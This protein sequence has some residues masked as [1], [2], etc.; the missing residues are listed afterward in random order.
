[1]T[2]RAKNNKAKAAPRNMTVAGATGRDMAKNIKA[3]L[4]KRKLQKFLSVR[5]VIEFKHRKKFDPAK[6]LPKDMFRVYK[7]INKRFGE[8]YALKVCTLL[9]LLAPVIFACGVRPCCFSTLSCPPRPRLFLPYARRWSCI[10][11]GT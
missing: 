7:E 2:L 5:H 4:K 8:D 11:R 10:G 1:M 9:L 6:Y 3:E